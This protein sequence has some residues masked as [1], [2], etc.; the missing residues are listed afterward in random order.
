MPQPG[1]RGEGWEVFKSRCVRGGGGGYKNFT[2]L[3]AICQ[4]TKYNILAYKGNIGTLF[5]YCFS[6]LSK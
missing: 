1:G 3:T 5:F 4:R 6:F 2:A